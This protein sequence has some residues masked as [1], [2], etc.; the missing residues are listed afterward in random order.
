VVSLKYNVIANYASQIF[1][2]I[3]GIVL[4]PMYIK[5]MGS[6]AYGLVGFFAM[7]QVWFGVLDLGLTPTIGRQTA[8]YN[9][10]A[11]S[12]LEFRQLYRILTVLFLSVAVIGGGALFLFSKIIA[13]QWLNI[14]NLNV[15]SVVISVQ[16]MAISVALRWMGGLYRGVVTGS[17]KLVWLGGYNVIIAILRFAGVF[18]SMWQFGFMP[19]VFFVHQFGVALIEV[20]GL[21]IKSE[22]L[23]PIKK[24]LKKNIG[25]SLEPIKPVLKFSLTIAATASIWAFVTQ[26]DKLVLSGVLPLTDYGYFTLAVLVA[27]AVMIIGGPISSAIMPR[28]AKLEAERNFEEVTRIYRQSTQLVTVIAGST[29]VTLAFCAEPLLLA[30]TGDAVLVSN[31]APILTLYAAG[32]GILSVAAFPY[33]LQYAKGD[34]R[35]HFIGHLLLLFILVPIIVIAAKQYGAIGAGYAW[36]I[37]TTLYLFIWVAVVHHKLQPGLHWKWLVKDVLTI[38][39]PMVLLGAVVSLIEFKMSSRLFNLMYVI[40]FGGGIFLVGTLMS[41]NGRDFISGLKLK[42]T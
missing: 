3:I 23:M 24:D 15:D 19:V 7:L 20:I 2:T 31:A 16:I 42:E 21:A 30:W 38:G 26:A 40:G 28:M 25:W 6:E 22:S 36:V 1:V 41:P 29:A 27:S 8:R 4:L 10:G 11:I 18:V 32:N 39:V 9:G 13:T 37:V 34:L 17:E 12:A 14:R 33:Y 35:Y 5:Y